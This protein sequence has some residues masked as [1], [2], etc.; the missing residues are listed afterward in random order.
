MNWATATWPAA[1]QV[2]KK[3]SWLCI[4]RLDRFWS[5]KIEHWHK[6]RVTLGLAPCSAVRGPEPGFVGWCLGTTCD[7][8]LTS[9][10]A[11]SWDGGGGGG[12][13][14]SITLLNCILQASNGQKWLVWLAHQNVGSAGLG[15]SPFCLTVYLYMSS[16]ISAPSRITDQMLPLL[17][18][19]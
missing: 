4:L 12:G 11:E 7:L 17:A 3:K 16:F 13:L 15:H 2:V 5:Q 18:T 8:S 1:T 19:F 10:D 6:Q 9:L 14:R